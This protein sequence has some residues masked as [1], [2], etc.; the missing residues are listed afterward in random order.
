MVKAITE[1]GMTEPFSGGV[2]RPFSS[3]KPG[4]ITHL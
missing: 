2:Y 1:V 3:D 4:H